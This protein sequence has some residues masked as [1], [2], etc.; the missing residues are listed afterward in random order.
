MEKRLELESGISGLLA[1][2]NV[3]VRVYES[4]GS[5]NDKMS[6]DIDGGFSDFPAACIAL[7]QTSGR[8]R[9][10][11]R[12]HSLGNAS[13]SLTVARRIAREASFAESFTV[14]V[15]C[16]LCGRLN[17][18]CGGNLKLKWP[19]DIYSRDGKKI[20]GMLSELKIL[21]G[22]NYIVLAGIGINVDFS[23]LGESDIPR[24]I[25][26]IYG[27]LKSNT[28]HVPPMAALAAAVISSVIDAEI[29]VPDIC[30]YFKKH[31]WL[32][33]RQVRLR[34]GDAIIEGIA[35]GVNELGNLLVRGKEGRVHFAKSGEASIIK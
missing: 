11:R 24:E 16:A 28:E 31:D 26:A 9:M 27:D 25:R 3:C 10:K 33:G 23:S 1:G 5:T 29:L 2:R 12:W 14:R 8:G 19:N 32:L 35:G 7:E 18:L 22:G 34:E 6:Q 17:D 21:P 20:S 4:L 15:G 30:A 13:L